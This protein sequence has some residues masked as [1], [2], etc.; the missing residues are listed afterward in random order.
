[1]IQTIAL[2]VIAFALLVLASVA[3]LA[4]YLAYQHGTPALFGLRPV[5]ELLLEIAEAQKDQANAARSIERKMGELMDPY[6]HMGSP[7]LNIGIHPDVMVKYFE[8]QYGPSEQAERAADI[9][10]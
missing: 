8:A 7:R 4:A 2:C 5:V 3:A 1:M 10:Q 6:P 9:F